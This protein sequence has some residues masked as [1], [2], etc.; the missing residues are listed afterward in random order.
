VRCSGLSWQADI[1]TLDAS[2]QPST[3]VR[4]QP[5]NTNAGG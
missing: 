1:V 4:A 3:T 2:Y 5:C